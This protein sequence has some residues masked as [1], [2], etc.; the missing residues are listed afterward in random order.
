VTAHGSTEAQRFRGWIAQ[1]LGLNFDDT[2]L[3][4]LADVLERRADKKGL[5]PRPYLDRLESTDTDAELQ[6]L[7]PDLTVPE[8][9]FF[10]HI[11]Q[12]H[13]F[14]DVALPQAQIARGSIRKLKILSAG[15]ASGEEPYSLAMLLRERG[16]DCGWNVEIHAMDINA[17]ML[18]KAS[19]GIY[20]AWALRETPAETKRRWF[21]NAGREFE[22]DERIRAAVTFHEVNLAQDR[23]ALWAP[24]TYD[25]IFCRNVSMYFAAE[26][27]QALVARITH[28]L[29]PGGHL[30]LG[31]AETLRGLSD[32]YHLCH[33]HGTFYYQRKSVPSREVGRK[34]ETQRELVP[35]Q[36]S[37]AQAVAA[38]APAAAA[39]AMAEPWTKTWLDTVQHASDRIRALTE[40]PTA[41]SAL[42]GGLGRGSAADVGAQ[43]Q[44]ALELLK[45]E[46]FAD[47]LELL[48]RLPATAEQDP[49]V[50]L[51]RAALLT[52][53]GDLS[54]AEQA[55]ARLLERDELN[56]GAHYLIA[57]C[58]E[59]AGD[60][61]GA[62]EHDQA[63]IYLDGAFAMPR[64]HLGLMA[65]RAGE[66]E[67][68][69]RELSQALTLLKRE[70]ASRLLL[71][72]GGFGREALIALCRAE[73]DSA[74]E[75]R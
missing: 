1:K 44:L 32:E 28:S 41:A 55:S 2:K 3:E 6:A 69:R 63:A 38:P 49:D 7:A 36:G 11:D 10:R 4:F 45:Q 59:S 74:G 17:P 67:T 54:A 16:A 26:A 33:T 30:F 47:A 20:S 60:R 34:Y 8:T 46:R 13:A 40:R 24:E 19:R 70:G 71:F 25:M 31:H 5:E 23:A 39:S 68:A 15:C 48:G 62:V 9:Y 18:A 12:F 53:S 37:S 27:A 22:L 21:K 35:P 66:R 57:L 42:Q 73:L 64:L 14:A 65:R 72:G 52:H 58:R 29:A 56:T 61:Q 51:L 75:A 43:L 50:L